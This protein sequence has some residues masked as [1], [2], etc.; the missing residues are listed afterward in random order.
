MVLGNCHAQSNPSIYE[1]KGKYLQVSAAYFS[2][3]DVTGMLVAP[4]Q[5]N[6]VKS[7]VLGNSGCSSV[8]VKRGLVA[9]KVPRVGTRIVCFV[10]GSTRRVPTLVVF[11]DCPY[12][13]SNVEATLYDQP[14]Y[15]VILG[16][17][18]GVKCPGSQANDQLNSLDAVTVETK[19]A[20]KR[21]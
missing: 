18:K 7:T 14:L 13:K 8:V 12:I 4:G 6:D 11:I 15:D 3:C 20:S 2:G 17:I 5:M 10:D 19:V 21:G 9:S 1:G 16:S